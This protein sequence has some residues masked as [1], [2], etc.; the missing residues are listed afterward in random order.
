[1]TELKATPRLQDKT[2]TAYKVLEF[3]VKLVEDD[4]KRLDMST[5]VSAYQ[6]ESRLQQCYK[7]PEQNMPDCG[8]VACLAGWVCLV[9]ETNPNPDQNGYG[10]NL[11]IERLG[12]SFIRQFTTVTYLWNLFYSFQFSSDDAITHLRW[13]MEKCKNVLVSSEVN[14]S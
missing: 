7:I 3:V 8:T 2:P 10:A 13:I 5:W 11:A 9:T 6:G 12:L 1:M 4:P 14:L